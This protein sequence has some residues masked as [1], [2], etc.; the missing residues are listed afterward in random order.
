M[1]K[2]E[3]R[4]QQATKE[5]RKKKKNISQ[6]LS[7]DF[8]FGEKQLNVGSVPAVCGGVSV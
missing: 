2:K 4:A 1:K 8:V 6:T 5:Q 7:D 3:Q